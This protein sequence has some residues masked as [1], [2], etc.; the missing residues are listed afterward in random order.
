[1]SKSKSVFNLSSHDSPCTVP[2]SLI[3]YRWTVRCYDHFTTLQADQGKIRYHIR[4]VSPSMA[5]TR[6]LSYQ[7]VAMVHII[8]GL[9]A[10][11][12]ETLKVSM[13]WKEG[14]TMA[15][16]GE[17]FY[18]GAVFLTTAS[19]AL[20][21]HKY[22]LTKLEKPF[23]ILS[24]LNAVLAGWLV[25]TSGSILIGTVIHST[26][27]PGILLHLILFL[28]GSIDLVVTIIFCSYS[29]SQHCR[30]CYLCCCRSCSAQQDTELAKATFAEDDHAEIVLGKQETVNQ[31]KQQ[32][33]DETQAGYARFV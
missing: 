22:S 5:A 16:L 31:V 15:S 30:C 8:A 28:T 27:L 10:L 32:N 29:C 6:G 21:Q 4:P 13:T 24:I 11:L 19:L 23:Y 17:G 9:A 20:V 7:V 1:M 26:H 12:V 33:R 3:C 18:C 14:Q 2:A 25:L